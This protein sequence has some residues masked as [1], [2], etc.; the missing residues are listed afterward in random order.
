MCGIAGLIFDALEPNG[1]HWLTAMTQRLYHRGPDDGGAVLFGIAGKPVIERRLG[2]PGEPVAWDYLAVQVG[3]GARRLAIIDTTEAGHQPMSSPDGQAWLVF[4]GAIY[5]YRE[6][7]SELAAR[8]MSFRGGS[9]TEVLLAAYRAWGMA[10]FERLEGMWAL[11]IYDVPAGRVILSRDRLGIKPLYV[12]RLEQGI[13]FASEI[14]AMLEVPGIP[15]EIEQTMLRDFLVRGLVD[16]TDNTLFDG[17]W[18]LP[19]G[20]AV[21]LELRGAESKPT[22]RGKIRRYWTPGSN[23]SKSADTTQRIRENLSAAVASHLVSDVSVGSCLSGGLDSST[24]VSLVNRL[25]SEDASKAPH[26]SQNAFTACLPGSPLDESKY[27]ESVINA[28]PG[29][30]W[31]RAEPTAA[32]LQRDMAS[33][34]WHQEQPFGS[35]SIY[36]QWE[37]MRLARESGVTVLLDGQGGDELFCGYQGYIPPFIAHL[38]SRGA[39]GRVWR[40]FHGAVREGHFGRI[41]LK[42]H[43]AAHLLPRHLRDAMRS[44]RDRSKLDW[45]AGDLFDTEPPVGIREGLG[46]KDDSPAAP[47]AESAIQRHLWSILLSESLPALLRFEDRNS[48]AFSIEARVPLLDRR[49][50]E[51]AMSIPIEEKI[52]DGR[53]KAVLREAVREIV[54]KPIVDRRDK[55]GFSAPTADWL[56][57]GLHDWW[58]EALTSNSFRD[59]GCF[60]PKGVVRMLKRFEAGDGSAALP[61]WRMAIVEQWARQFL[62]QPAAI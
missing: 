20:C 62:D 29:L 6:L 46:L 58:L 7:R 52:R 40:E 25:A 32:R 39:I 13:A 50:A 11:A 35:P 33:L 47:D 24:I 51:L 23:V 4:N 56:R 18:S 15:R 60:A 9:D 19:P 34:V 1:G 48:M 14:K 27:A 10:S 38:I 59:R 57:G 44:A 21:T 45:L 36:M 61:I 12:T 2:K 37:V 55:I 17:I 28:C 8:G 26:W 42:A 53:L 22:R 5:N 31:H 41:A 3:L 54:P 43:I 16:H 30:H 49:V